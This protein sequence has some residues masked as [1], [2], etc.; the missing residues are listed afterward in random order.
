MPTAFR[1]SAFALALALLW[2]AGAR[3]DEPYGDLGGFGEE[4][5][6]FS[7]VTVEESPS[8]ERWW[9]LDGDVTVSTSVAYLSHHADNPPL[10]TDWT[11]L[12]RLRARLNLELDVDLPRDFKLRVSPYI[13]YDLAYVINDFDNF[14]HQVL[15]DYEWEWDFQ[16]SYIEGPL[17]DHLDVKIGRQVVNWGRSD[18]LRVVDVLNPLD[19]REPGRADI[20][21]LRWSVGMAKLDW[22]TDHWTLTG[23]AVP[24]IRFDTLPVFGSDFYPYPF[25]A[26]HDE[27]PKSFEHWEFAGALSGVFA[28]W[29]ASLHYAW[30]YN[31]LA[32]LTP[33]GPT[34]LDLKQVHDR[35]HMVG[36]TG[37]YA[38]GAWLAKAEIAWLQ[39]FRYAYL[40]PVNPL[41]PVRVS[42]EKSR[43]DT[44]LGVEYYGF[45]DTTLSLDVA[46]RHIFDYEGII[47]GFP[48]VLRENTG[49]YAVRI[50]RE[51]LHARL[52]TTV[53]ALIFGWAAQDGA[54]IRWQGDY[55]LRDG[56]VLTVGMLIYQAGELPP[57]D[58]WG[59]NDRVFIDLKWS[60]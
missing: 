29:D 51:W 40:D 28:G 44:L 42:D 24:E 56:L 60:F 10:Y 45:T 6:T 22:H 4:D 17:T 30:I 46:N 23:I 21:A 8:P 59:R 14:T 31:D 47:R 50:T 49:E 18:S 19:N 2:G 38:W 12:A 35:L 5:E 27:K 13:W 53:L 33:D 36:A 32:R 16:D 57:L 48:T 58:T 3:A 39:G 25:P 20:E 52:S 9:D 11:G 54:V 43:L 7:D 55:T 15:D 34:V 37:N 41:A 1:G 26:P